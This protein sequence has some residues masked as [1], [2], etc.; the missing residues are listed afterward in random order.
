MLFINISQRSFF[1]C[2]VNQC[3]TGSCS[4]AACPNVKIIEVQCNA[5]PVDK[6]KTLA[7]L[8]T[9]LNGLVMKIFRDGGIGIT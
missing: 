1:I 2:D 6:M 5:S 3:I 7:T 9:T 8:M 4:L